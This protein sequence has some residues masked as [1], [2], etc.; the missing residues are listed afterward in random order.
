MKSKCCNAKVKVGGKG[1]THYYVC[2]K[3]NKPCDVK[4]SK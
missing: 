1:M 2:T 4:E 3:C